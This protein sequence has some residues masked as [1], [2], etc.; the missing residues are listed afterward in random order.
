M[1]FQNYPFDIQRCPILIESF[2]HKT[3]QI[4]IQWLQGP[5]AVDV[6]ENGLESENY[7]K[8]GVEKTNCT[9]CYTAGCFPCLKLEFVLKR[10]LGYFLVQVYTITYLI[11]FLH[12]SVA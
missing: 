4:Q 5:S 12:Q 1:L 8:I 9:G 6:E 7:R 2:K 3:D 11:A 10:E